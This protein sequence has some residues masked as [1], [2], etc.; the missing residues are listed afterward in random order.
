MDAQIHLT[1][2]LHSRNEAILLRLVTLEI[3]TEVEEI[4]ENFIIIWTVFAPIC[5]TI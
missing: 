3:L 1:Q 2:I 4:S 5:H